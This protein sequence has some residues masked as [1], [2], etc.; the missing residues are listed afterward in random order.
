VGAPYDD[1]GEVVGEANATGA[2]AAYV[3]RYAGGWQAAPKLLPAGNGLAG[4]N[5]G[6][7]VALS[8]TGILCGASG[9][10]EARGIAFLFE[11]DGAGGWNSRPRILQSSTGTLNFGWS[12]ALDHGLAAVGAGAQGSTHVGIVELYAPGSNGWTSQGTLE[13][14]ASDFFSSGLT[15]DQRRIAVG[16]IYDSS[17]HFYNWPKR[18]AE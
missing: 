5:M 15:I 18:F 2:G 17:V 10:L 14:N 7:A 11:P 12:V 4:A 6:R 16:A 8:T 1:N 9:Y 3:F 13:T